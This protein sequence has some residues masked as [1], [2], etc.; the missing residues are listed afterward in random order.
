MGRRS[1]KLPSS[2]VTDAW[3]TD[4]I[5]DFQERLLAAAVSCRRRL[6]E[7]QAERLREIVDNYVFSLQDEKSSLPAGVRLWQ[8]AY[9]SQKL[10]L[11]FCLTLMLRLMGGGNHALHYES[12]CLGLPVGSAARVCLENPVPE[13]SR[14]SHGWR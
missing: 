12:I 5:P 4:T 8:N 2:S 14:V 3:S 9:T 7:G 13:I 1:S 11:N 10:G 6:D